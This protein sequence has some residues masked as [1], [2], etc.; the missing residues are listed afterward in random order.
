[1]H[2]PRRSGGEDVT[3]QPALQVR[4]QRNQ[5][6]R[7]VGHVVNDIF[8]VNLAV[9][10]S[11]NLELQNIVHLI[12]GD[13]LRAEAEESIKALDEREEARVLAQ[14]RFLGH[15]ENRGIADDIV[16]PVLFVD[17]LALFAEDDAQLGL[18]GG[19]LRFGQGGNAHVVP[20]A[21]NAG[22]RLIEAAREADRGVFAQIAR[23]I[24]IVQADSENTGRV[25]VHSC[26]F[27]D[28]RH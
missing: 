13:K 2:S 4:C 28:Q 17:E 7:L 5:A 12:G 1:M 18:A 6:R 24:D 27:L 21:D 22:G 26:L 8:R 23:V 20:R 11:L 9:M 3:R 14:N 19:F 25:A 16:H 15:I 10:D